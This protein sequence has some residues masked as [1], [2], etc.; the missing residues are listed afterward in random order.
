MAS[1]PAHNAADLQFAG[2]MYVFASDAVLIASQARGRSADPQI[3]LFA[4][5]LRTVQVSTAEEV[6]SWFRMWGKPV[7]RNSDAAIR[8][9]GGVPSSAQLRE[10][11]AARGP[12]F[13]RAFL[14]LIIADQQ[15]ALAAATLEQEGGAFGPARQLAAQMVSSSTLA[16]VRLDQMLKVVR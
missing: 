3:A 4:Q 5:G 12:A 11:A 7:P 10:L 6:S 9:T 16:I 15:G 13:D 8:S 14:K 2:Q 1:P